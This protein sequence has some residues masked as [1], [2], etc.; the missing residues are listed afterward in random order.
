MQLSS[1]I[2][3]LTSQLTQKILTGRPTPR[4]TRAPASSRRRNPPR[5][6][7][8][9]RLGS[10]CAR[11]L[12]D[13]R[14]SGRQLA[15]SRY[16]AA[17][18]QATPW[19]SQPAFGQRTLAESSEA[20]DRMDSHCTPRPY[21]DCPRLLRCRT[22]ARRSSLRRRAI[23]TRRAPSGRRLTVP[24]FPPTSPC[25]NRDFWADVPHRNRDHRAYGV[26]RRV[27]SF[28][29]YNVT[30]ARR[31]VLCAAR[32]VF[33][34]RTFKLWEARVG[35]LGG[36][37]AT[38]T[39]NDASSARSTFHRRSGVPYLAI[40]SARRHAR[41]AAAPRSEFR[42]CERDPPPSPSHLQCLLAYTWDHRA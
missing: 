2:C 4:S 5:P 32:Y 8:H 9:H 25:G 17:C 27:H 18:D 31:L 16:Q 11:N 37:R 1:P 3:S 35:A 6:R 36:A 29:P 38:L 13:R 26:V 21:I 30:D 15:F 20:Q 39:R 23:T 19:S 28:F 7:R 41:S 12:S 40:S 33:L 22:D 14:S 24:I 34:Q 10:H 42:A